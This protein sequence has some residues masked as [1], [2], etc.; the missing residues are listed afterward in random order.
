MKRPFT[1]IRYKFIFSMTVIF[2][3]FA[4]AVLSIWYNALK[5]EAASTA[6]RNSEHLLQVSNTIFEKQ[7]MD[8]INVAALTSV[9]SS[10]S[11]STNII[12][13]LS[14]NDLTDAEIVNYRRTASD[15]LISLCSFKNNLN[16]LM[17][18]DFDGNTITYGL[19]TS[20]E[21]MSRNNWISLVKDSSNTMFFIPPHYPHEWYNTQK[22]MVFSVLKPV[23]GFT[24][25]KIGF[26]NADIS[27]NLFEEC[28]NTSSP[29]S[30]SLYVI[31]QQEGRVLFHPSNNLLSLESDTSVLSEI[32]DRITSNSGHF[33][34]QDSQN[35]NTLVVYRTSSLTN[36][37][38][39]NM[40]PE[41]EIVSA[42]TDTL[43]DIILITLVLV[44]A[45]IVCVFLITSLLTQKIRLL[46]NAVRRIDGDNLD[47]PIYINTKDEIGALF[48]QFKSMLD[49][50]KDL[51]WEV[52]DKE[53]AKHRA[54]IGALQFQMNP[55]FL[56]NSLNTIKFLS[57]LQGADN[58]GKVAESLSSMMH[59]NMDGRSFIRVE[60]DKKF[61]ESYLE[62]QNYRYTNTFQFQIQVQKDAAACM[63]PKL[64]VQPLVEN[65]LKHGLKEKNS[66][67]ILLADYH[68]DEDCLKI[69]V[70]DNGQGISEERIQEILCNN[71]NENAGHIGIHNIRERLHMYFGSEYDIEIISQ[72]GIFTRFEI[73]L[74]LIYDNEVTNYV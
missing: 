44:A 24:R 35:G 62:I 32:I 21:T 28:F 34:I 67:G 9:R 4:A 40:I 10:N 65:A 18:S 57:S 47:L 17:L 46:A 37:T 49:R 19:P 43:H 68:I 26:V 15:Y 14:R 20:F 48:S 31:N 13:I 1:S 72:P 3:L 63:I 42:F 71:Q 36:W 74:P 55:H 59:I 45:L 5:K 7:V 41:K 33:F 23:Y 69:I 29:S 52:K 8:I 64:L 27:A 73:I 51:L 53:K 39:L 25:Q 11:L 54:E 70:E 50:I 12:T 2:L 58:I 61:L 66:D 38:T 6:I 30:S 22:D 56:Y 16:G 60:E